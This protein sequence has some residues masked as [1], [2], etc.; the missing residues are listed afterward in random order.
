[1]ERKTIT[2]TRFLGGWVQ[3]ARVVMTYQ[4]NVTEIGLIGADGYNGS[5]IVLFNNS[6]INLCKKESTF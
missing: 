6:S 3:A 4:V 1:L 5:A 2:E